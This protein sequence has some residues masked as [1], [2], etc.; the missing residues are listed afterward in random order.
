MTLVTFLA[1]FPILDQL[2]QETREFYLPIIE[3]RFKHFEQTQDQGFLDLLLFT[4]SLMLNTL[5]KIFTGPLI[6]LFP[7]I[8]IGIIARN[9]I[10]LSYKLLPGVIFFI[11]FLTIPFLKLGWYPRSFLFNLPIILIFFSSGIIWFCEM[12]N[13]FMKLKVSIS[14]SGFALLYAFFSVQLIS[15]NY[16]SALN[17]MS[18][19]LYKQK[20]QQNS[21]FQDLILISNPRNYLYA[22]SVFRD[23][24]S[25]II[26]SNNLSGIQ[27][28]CKNR[29]TLEQTKLLDGE[30][31]FKPFLALSKNQNLVESPISSEIKILKLTS[32]K[33]ITMIDNKFKNSGNWHLVSGEGD[34]LKR[35]LLK[36][37]NEFLYIL[38][39]K[40]NMTIEASIPK[41]NLQY[42]SFATLT[43]CGSKYYPELVV[44][45]LNFSYESIS[46]FKSFRAHKNTQFLRTGEMNI[47]TSTY[48]KI[49]NRDL[50]QFPL[51]NNVLLGKIPSGTY[52]MSVRLNAKN[53]L[54]ENYSCLRLFFSPIKS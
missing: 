46:N 42:D 52:E 51:I 13:K 37:E 25:K 43:W 5:K 48:T 27:I 49:Q 50:E 22:R 28:I 20:I 33:S 34:Y 1:Y 16:A 2:I 35:T 10:R 19:K 29:T 15:V 11:P 53:A 47:G 41:F 44:K 6:F 18:G 54:P 17:P 9:T 3:N 7:F 40:S 36:P 31:Y 45:N 24:L 14:L 38:K 32:S 39:P 26:K 23:N 30:G 8:L 12:L 4:W 21:N